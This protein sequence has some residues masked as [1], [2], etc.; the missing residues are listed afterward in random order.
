MGASTG[1]IQLWDVDSGELRELGHH[2]DSVFYVSFSPDGRRLGTASLDKLAKVWDLESGTVTDLRGHEGIVDWITFSP[3]SRTIATGS[4]DHRLRFWDPGSSVP[5]VVDASGFIVQGL[6]FLS[7]G[8]SILAYSGGGAA[9]LWDVQSGKTLRIF[10]GHHGNITALKLARDGL[11]F[12]TS[13]DDRTVRFYDIATGE[14]RVMGVHE[15]PVRAVAIEP[16]SQWVVSAGDDGAVRLWS[17]E[18]PREPNALRAWIAASV[19]DVI[20]VSTLGEGSVP[21]P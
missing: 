3:D 21:L 8:T 5:R 15:G 1:L 18:L 17:D 6:A 7:D 12:A 20:D 9:R 11:S 14:S 16:N 13:S 2:T 4:Y 10:R 19:T